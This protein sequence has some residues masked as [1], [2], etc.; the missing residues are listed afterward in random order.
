MYDNEF[1][2]PL[3][4]KHLNNIDYYNNLNKDLEFQVGNFLRANTVNPKLYSND[5]RHQY[6]SALYAR[7]L[8]ADTAK[9]LG[10]LNELINFSGSGREDTQID[11]INNS[12]G[13]NYGLKYPNL[14]KEQLLYKLLLFFVEFL[15]MEYLLLYYLKYLE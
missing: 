11:K 12:I 5:I 1:N 6:A 10:D 13:R 14:P 2:K 9:R 7:N 4:F 3:D 8:G 15:V